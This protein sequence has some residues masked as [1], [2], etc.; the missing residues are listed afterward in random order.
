MPYTAQKTQYSMAYNGASC[1]FDHTNYHYYPTSSFGSEQNSHYSP[2]NSAPTSSYPASH[3]SKTPHLGT[4]QY[5]QPTYQSNQQTLGVPSGPPPDY[6]W[7]PNPS[8][9]TS[10]TST[11]SSLTSGTTNDN[12]KL[13]WVGLDS[14]LA[15]KVDAVTQTESPP[16][17]STKKKIYRETAIQC[18]LQTLAHVNVHFS[19][20]VPEEPP[21]HHLLPKS[22]LT[23]VLSS[24][25]DAPTSDHSEVT[26]TC[27]ETDEGEEGTQQ[28]SMQADSECTTTTSQEEKLHSKKN[29]TSLQMRQLPISSVPN[30][31]DY[32][33]Q[34]KS[35]C[36]KCKKARFKSCCALCEKQFNQLCGSFCLQTYG[37]LQALHMALP[38][39]YLVTLQS[40]LSTSTVPEQATLPVITNHTEQQTQKTSE[41]SDSDS[42]A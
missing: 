24:K 30:Y 18:A 20:D 6:N 1:T 41:S 2:Y 36:P 33:L 27:M 22:I 16:V 37:Y 7:W 23:E 12:T 31:Q 28:R 9:A 4:Y 40:H 14:I 19:G 17:L 35:L 15:T 10:V 13:D 29:P 11:Q 32:Y 38:K 8:P 34:Q 21:L 26:E 39:E 5:N 25:E 42:E 3:R